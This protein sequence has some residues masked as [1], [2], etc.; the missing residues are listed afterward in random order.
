MHRHIK[1][2]RH[3]HYETIL[4]FVEN[5]KLFMLYCIVNKFWFWV[6]SYLKSVAATV[7]LQF[8]ELTIA[9]LEL[10]SWH[11]LHWRRSSIPLICVCD[12]GAELGQCDNC[13]TKMETAQPSS[14]VLRP[15]SHAPWTPAPP[16]SSASGWPSSL[17]RRRSQFKP[18]S[19]A[20]GSSSS[21]PVTQRLIMN[22]QFIWIINLPALFYFRKQIKSLSD[23]NL[24]SPNTINRR[25][26][27]LRSRPPS[28]FSPSSI[29]TTSSSPR[30]SSQLTNTPPSKVWL[31]AELLIH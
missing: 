6:N 15:L 22:F 28:S 2:K 16:P 11:S 17:F 12:N 5:T 31:I 29:Q 4:C 1:C 18:G 20:S 9:Q 25:N 26:S 3:L 7:S 27:F 23:D 21:T 13:D 8:A 24:L 19:S 14:K 10:Q 30:L